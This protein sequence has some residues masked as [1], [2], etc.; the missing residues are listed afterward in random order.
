MLIQSGVGETMP[1]LNHIVVC[2]ALACTANN[3]ATDPDLDT[4]V[5]P[6]TV[7]LVQGGI[8]TCAAPQYRQK[9]AYS[10]QT[11]D[12]EAS[13][14]PYLAG[15][16]AAVVDVDGDGVLDLITATYSEVQLYF[17][18]KTGAFD[19]RVIATV[20][21]A[22]PARGLFGITA[23]DLEDDGDMDL[24]V[25]GLG[26][27]NL[28]LKNDGTGGFT[29]VAYEIGLVTPPLHYSAG[30]A[31]VDWDNDGDLDIFISGHGWVNEALN[32]SELGPA[33]PS[34]LFENQ[35]GRYVDIGGQLPQDVQDAYTFVGGFFDADRDGDLDLYMVNDFGATQV[36]CKLLHNDGT[37]QFTADNNASLID[38]EIAGMGLAIGDYDGDGDEDLAVPAWG[39][40]ALYLDS[41]GAWF[42][43][44]RARGFVADPS[45]ERTVGWGTEMVDTNNDGRMDLP[46]QYGF[47]DTNIGTN[48]GPD[49]FDALW[50]Q[51]EDRRLIEAPLQWRFD[52][53]GRAHR[54][55]VWADI[56]RDGFL[57]VVRIGLRGSASLLTSYCDTNAWLTVSLEQPAPNRNA[58]GAEVEVEH[59]GT[60]TYRRLRA[61]G[62]GY[63]TSGPPEIHLGLGDLDTADLVRVR[64]PDG[65]VDEWT[66]IATRQHL[67]ITRESSP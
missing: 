18:D 10:I 41:E 4:V 6:D 15:A 65:S 36:P 44:S 13:P 45:P 54:G 31:V 57:D 34:F 5:T 61:G 9:E 35:D 47:L 58:I 12:V 37:G 30:S 8:T 22:A 32:A 25:T 40:N 38:A 48:N 60:V 16:G 39:R 26:T 33:N 43:V 19:G 46:T 21:V 14:F 62:T 51:G 28:M 56:N 20:D 7:T 17:A 42:E 67:H 59:N 3:A 1:R 50:L 55:A 49:Q 11:L 29:D 66:D 52:V 2:A 24:L 23:F 63:G 53:Q 64:W 27:R